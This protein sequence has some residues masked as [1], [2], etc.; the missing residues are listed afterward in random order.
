MSGPRTN[1]RRA[2]TLRSA[3]GAVAGGLLPDHPLVHL[4]G[5]LAGQHRLEVVRVPHDRVVE[6]DP[7]RAEGPEDDAEARGDIF[8]LISGALNPAVSVG[9]TNP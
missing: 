2:P 5:A 3:E 1:T 4:R 6:R 7:G 8:L 9:T